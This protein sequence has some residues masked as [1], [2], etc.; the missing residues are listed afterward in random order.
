MRGWRRHSSFTL[1]RKNA[2]LVTLALVLPT[3]N[4]GSQAQ[5]PIFIPENHNFLVQM[6]PQASW[7]PVASAESLEARSPQPGVLSQASPARI[8]QPGVLSKGSSA[9]VPQPGFLGQ[10]SSARIP[11]PG[12]LSL[13][14]SARMPQPEV[15]SQE[16]TARSPQQ[17]LESPANLFGVRAGVIFINLIL[18]LLAYGTRS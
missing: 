6:A 15:V 3:R 13:D 9:R 4:R 11:R 10:E 18:Q 1:I 12:F 5:T 14:A 7:P 2:Y 17:E 8:P 16:S